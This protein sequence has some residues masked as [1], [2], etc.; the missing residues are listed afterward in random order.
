VC[1]FTTSDILDPTFLQDH[2]E[3]QLSAVIGTSFVPESNKGTVEA[4]QWTHQEV[5]YEHLVQS[6]K[7]RWPRRRGSVLW[8]YAQLSDWRSFEPVGNQFSGNMIQL[9]LDRL[10]EREAGMEISRQQIKEPYD[11]GV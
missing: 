6:S 2:I 4:W 7:L 8:N 10:E 1:E 11:Q 3:D 5:P 9:T